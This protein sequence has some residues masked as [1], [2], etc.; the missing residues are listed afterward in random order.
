MNVRCILMVYYC[1]NSSFWLKSAYNFG[2]I[3]QG[4]QDRVL[5]VPKIVWGGP[6]ATEDNF[7]TNC[8]KKRGWRLVCCSHQR[9]RRTRGWE[10]QTNRHPSFAWQFVPKSFED[11][12]HNDLFI[13]SHTKP[14]AVWTKWKHVL[15]NVPLRFRFWQVKKTSSLTI[16]HFCCNYLM[17]LKNTI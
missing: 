8:H 17:K 3:I 11:F 14:E 2:L 5:L 1:I 7:F 16:D 12:H 6:W 9:V 13:C 4:P 15:W 10:Q